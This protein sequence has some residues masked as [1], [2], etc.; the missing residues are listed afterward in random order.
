MKNLILIIPIILFG[1]SCNPTNIRDGEALEHDLEFIYVDS[2]GNDLLYSSNEFHYNKQ[3]IKLYY[4]NGDQL[5]E[6]YYKDASAPKGFLINCSD[7]LHKCS[8]DL[9]ASLY[10]DSENASI[11]YLKLSDTDTDTIKCKYKG[12]LDYSYQYLIA[13][14]YNGKL[15]FGDSVLIPDKKLFTIVK[16]Q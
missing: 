1:F 14:W 10:L 7:S 15:L 3:E 9:D 4:Q 8:L 12:G 13:A 6:P 5:E 11:T 2:A 16:S